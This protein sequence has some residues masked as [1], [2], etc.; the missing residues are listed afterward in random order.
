MRIRILPNTYVYLVLLILLIPLKWLLAWSIA[1]LVHEGCHLLAVYL[2]SG[3]VEGIFVKIGGVVMQGSILSQ[4]KRLI[5]SLAGPLGGFLLVLFGRHIPRTA[6]CSW[7]LSVYNLLPL[8]SL[9]GG[10]ILQ[11]LLNSERKMHIVESCVYLLL[12]IFAVFITFF[13]KLGI[14]PLL[15]VTFLWL[16]HRKIPCKEGLFKIQ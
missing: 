11:I 6:L 16:K 5:C 12:T 2:C 15:A 7:L 8:H 4:R 10:Q 1:V 14:L 9:D 3:R 13:L